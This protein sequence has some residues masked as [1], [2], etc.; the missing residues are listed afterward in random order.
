MRHRAELPGGDA[1]RYA[2]ASSPQCC[3]AATITFRKPSL[4]N[5]FAPM[6]R[7]LTMVEDA[8]ASAYLRSL[9]GDAAQLQFVRHSRDLVHH[10]KRQWPEIIVIGIGEG[11]KPAVRVAVRQILERSL[12]TRVF[13]M[14][15]LDPTHMRTLHQARYLDA[16]DIIFVGIDSRAMTRD[17]LLRIDYGRTADTAVRR[18]V[19]TLA[20]KWL[21][22]YVDWC[23]TG[24]GATRL[25]V[26][27]LARIGNVCRE[28]L[29]RRFK[30]RGICAPNALL[31]WIVLLR[32]AARMAVPRTSLG[33]IARELGL[34]SGASLANLFVRRAEQTATQV[35]A[36]GFDRFAERAVGEILGRRQARRPHPQPRRSSAGIRIAT[37]R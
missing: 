33:S 5:Q 6:L 24:A 11:A 27:G 13:V 32:A 28:T 4:G 29:A 31:A 21:Q 15:R 12:A 7:I 14:C 26:R 1:G 35:R 22:P 18:L 37:P 3:A 17:R 25:D 23:L 9:I 8:E 10:A 19:C 36:Q 2:N 16:S 20:P 30:A 34:A